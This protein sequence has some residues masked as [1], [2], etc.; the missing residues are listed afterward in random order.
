MLTTSL[1][2]R[3]TLGHEKREASALDDLSPLVHDLM[4]VHDDPGLPERTLHRGLGPTVNGIADGQRSQDL[5]VETHESQNYQRWPRH[6]PSQ[7]GGQA[8]REELGNHDGIH[9]AVTG[10]PAVECHVHFRHRDGGRALLVP[11]QD[12]LEVAPGLGVHAGRR[13]TMRSVSPSCTTSSRWFTTWRS[14]VTRPR[15]GFD[16]SR[17]AV[18][19]AR[20]RMVSPILMG[21]L[22][23]QRRPTKARVA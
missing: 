18:T 16:V 19:R 5:P 13:S 14:T 23:F 1:A 15:S 20:N 7:S 10:E 21:T 3:R 11:D 22:N 4:L 2:S 9:R 17:L 6:S 8:H 12:V